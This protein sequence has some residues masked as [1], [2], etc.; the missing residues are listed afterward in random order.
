MRILVLTKRQYMAKDLLDDRFGRFWQLPLELAR[1]GLRVQGIA[2]SYRPRPEG[3]FTSETDAPNR[4][5]NW[6]AVNLLD[7]GWPA[8]RRYL[9]RARE[10]ATEFQ[11]DVLWA[12]SD[13]YHAIFGAKLADQ[14]GSKCVIDLYDNF[15][16]YSAT[17]IP[18][19]VRLFK[20]ALRSAGGVTCVSSQLAAY[21]RDH[22]QCRAPRLVLENAVRVDLF[23]PLDRIACRERLGLP[24]GAK[25]I[26][27]G[28]A[29]YKSRGTETLYRGFEL[30]AAKDRNLHLAVAGPRRKTD[31]VPPGDRIHDLGNLPLETVP[32]F[33]NAL[34]VSVI[35]NRDSAFGRYNFPQKAREILACGTPLVA[36]A[37]G[38]MKEVLREHPE[39]LFAPDDPTSLA[40]AIRRQLE[41]PTK[42][43]AEIPSWADMAMQLESFFQEVLRHHP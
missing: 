33:F 35:S 9:R 5:V 6:H 20:R 17:K 10:I 14:I 37:V 30:L 18:G 7:R 19:V 29:L 39:C 2:L 21:V 24:K 43:R 23:R 27:A 3:L 16:S 25:I 32:S 22:Y 36:A 12:C 38:T 11:P 31:K 42:I 40:N 28:G 34:D 8:P 41:K 13:A 4:S 26:G 1:R 15:E